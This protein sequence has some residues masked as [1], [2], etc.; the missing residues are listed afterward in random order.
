MKRTIIGSV[1]MITGA[2]ITLSLVIIAVPYA[3]KI[4]EWRGSKLWFTIF[5]A[6]DLAN[7]QSLSMGLPFTIGIILFII[8]LI[9]LV[10]E[11]FNK[12]DAKR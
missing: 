10:M 6:K 9:I 1:I 3:S 2:I 7:S 8:G 11:Y 4:T 12:D 5:G